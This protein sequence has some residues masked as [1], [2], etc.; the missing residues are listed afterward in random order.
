MVQ[1]AHI[2]AYSVVGMPR[3][4]PELYEAVID[5]LDG[6]SDALGRCSL[7][8]RFFAR[9]CQ[10][11]L[12]KSI[13][14]GRPFKQFEG[15]IVSRNWPSQKLHQILASSPHLS[16]LI[17]QLEISDATAMNFYREEL[18]WIRRDSDVARVLPLLQNLESLVIAG[19]HLGSRMNFRAWKRELKFAVLLKAST[20]TSISLAYVR[21]VPWMIF[22]SVPALKTLHL[23]QVSFVPN[24]ATILPIDRELDAN[25]TQARLETL[26]IKTTSREEWRSLYLWLQIDDGSFCFDHI[27]DLSLDID[28][29]AQEPPVNIS[30]ELQG[31]SWLIR[32]CSSS[33]QNL[34][35]FFP[36][37]GTNISFP[38]P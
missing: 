19:N 33:L 21:N 29:V 23:Y 4:P 15:D 17:R 5:Q 12:F 6:D 16:H 36:E 35:L 10:Q 37:E 26:H 38:C 24:D 8:S 7:V 9:K 11:L 18:S 22:K 28:F 3:L 34:D 32:R 1:P 27:V 25:S 31:I 30:Q 20:V 14:L 13:T 2:A